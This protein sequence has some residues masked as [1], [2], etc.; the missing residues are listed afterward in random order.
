MKIGKLLF[1]LN[2]K[3]LL[4]QHQK[5]AWE[6]YARDLKDKVMREP[7]TLIENKVNSS[8]KLFQIST[9]FFLLSCV[10]SHSQNTQNVTQIHN[11]LS[12]TIN[13]RSLIGSRVMK[14]FFIASLSF[15]LSFRYPWISLMMHK[16]I[17]RDYWKYE[18]MA[19]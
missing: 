19:L 8:E 2:F 14:T 6:A 11:K 15:A 7:S 9:T 16:F 17:E 4:Q 12:C 10:L 13:S 1:L 5:C 18:W 3:P